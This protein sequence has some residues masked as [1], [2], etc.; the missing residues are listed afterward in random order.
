M[1]KK[2]ILES[3]I[4]LCLLLMSIFY[5]SVNK[6]NDNA[7]KI[8]DAELLESQRIE[9]ERILENNNIVTKKNDFLIDKY[10]SIGYNISDDALLL[11][12]QDKICGY[13]MIKDCTSGFFMTFDSKKSISYIISNV[14]KK[15]NL[16]LFNVSDG[17]SANEVLTCSI[18][19]ENFNKELF[20]DMFVLSN[21]F[22]YCK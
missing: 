16:C 15:D 11:C 18:Y 22:R 6:Y 4:F 7:E 8:D 13:D 17:V 21:Y 3:F 12:N 10:K 19:F 20:N 1:N 14:T 2:Y 5:I 9:S